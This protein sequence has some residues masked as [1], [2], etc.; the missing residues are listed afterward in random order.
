MKPHHAAQRR[1][2][3]H[4]GTPKTGSTA[5]QVFLAANAGILQQHGYAYPSTARRGGGHHDLAFLHSGG[6]PD[7][8]TPNDQPLK[9]LAQHLKVEILREPQNANIILSSENFYWLCSAER[10]AHGLAELGLNHRETTIVVYL[11]RQ[12]EVIASW[13]NQAVKALGYS[14]TQEEHMIEH[15]EL[16]DYPARLAAWE[17][18]FG[19]HNIHVR[20]YSVETD[21]CRDFLATLG[22]PETNFQFSPKRINPPLNRDLLEFQRLLNRL[23][24][25]T[26]EKRHFHKLLT[27]LSENTACTSL[28]D[29]QPL[30]PPATQ[31]SIR[32]LFAPGNRKIAEHYLD[33]DELFPPLTGTDS[34]NTKPAPYP[35]MTVE[36]MLLIFGWLLLSL[37]QK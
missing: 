1:C 14:G 20:P 16:W 25:P 36:K 32:R 6:Y 11:R 2:I 5:L 12:E 10:V 8:A 26:V 23:P 27:Q 33:R 24:L 34:S 3:L 31:A 37:N 29:T 7:W 9:L 4:I 22:L 18:T 17:A 13:Y 28:F 15:T 35:G 21:I 19:H 30:L